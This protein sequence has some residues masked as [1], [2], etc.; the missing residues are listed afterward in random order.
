MIKKIIKN[1]KA[2]TPLMATF[3]LISFAVA[4]GV[5]IMNL[6][7]AEVEESAE[8]PISLGLKFSNIGGED[9]I[10]YDSAAKK[11]KFTVENGVNA[12]VDGLVINVIGE[13]KA[14][15]FDVNEAKI[16]KAGT[17]LGDVNYDSSVSGNIR[18]LKISPKVILYDEEQICTEQALVAEEIGD[19]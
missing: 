15:S 14:E 8:C 6:G 9:Q 16:I 3:L 2:I 7:S 12:K 4:L 13:K 5:T 10:C 1:K 18:Q 11:L 19:C 17:F